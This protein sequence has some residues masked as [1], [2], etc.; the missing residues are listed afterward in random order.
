MKISSSWTCPACGAR[1]PVELEAR[2]PSTA[3]PALALTLIVPDT[4]LADVFAHAWTHH[5]ETPT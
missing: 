2:S 1:V 4:A 3:R 5:E